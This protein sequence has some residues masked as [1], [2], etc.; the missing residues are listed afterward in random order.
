[1]CAAPLPLIHP[2]RASR[3]ACCLVVL[4]AATSAHASAPPPSSVEFFEKRIRPVLAERCYGC[5]SAKAK[6]IRGGL[7]LDSRKALL[8]GGE[9]G[10]AVV[11]GKPGASLLIKAVR[12][13]HPTLRM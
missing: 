10:S 12:Y 8:D 1:M 4:L 11:P 3:L 9:S 7:R 5:H 13:T 2:L 6:A